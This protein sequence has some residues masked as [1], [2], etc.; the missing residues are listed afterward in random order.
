MIPAASRLAGLLFA[1]LLGAG[2]HAQY[3]QRSR[4]KDAVLAGDA[5]IGTQIQLR[6]EQVC[7]RRKPDP[8]GRIQ[9]DCAIGL[10][11]D[12]ERFYGL[13]AADPAQSRP[14]PE[15]RRVRVIGKLVPSRDDRFEESGV[16]VYSSIEPIDDPKRLTG[17]FACMSHG[18]STAHHAD[19]CK[20]I[21]TTDG[22]FRWGL[23]PAALER[24]GMELTDGQRIS[25]EGEILRS[26]HESWH[27]WMS[28]GAR[29]EIQGVLRVTR[30]Q[31]LPARSR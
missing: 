6:G 21:V 13:R 18:S 5:V 1:A 28:Y 2:A 23:D 15:L 24:L 17:T 19:A 30:L 25:V 8:D 12:D 16:I 4:D 14:L 31:R 3:T 20:P 27:P 22:G 11:G 9:L 7:L 10:R 29:N 26:V